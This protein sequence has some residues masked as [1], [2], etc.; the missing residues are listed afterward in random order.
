M[1]KIQYIDNLSVRLKEEIDLNFLHQ[2]GEVFWVLDSQ[3]SGNLCFGV[4][5]GENKYFIKFAGAKTI[6]NHDLPPEDAID[7]L[8]A[9]SKKYKDLAHPALIKLRDSMEIGNGYILIFDWETGNSIGDQNLLSRERFYSLSIDIR[10]N[11][12]SKILQFHKFVISSG[13]IA[14]DFNDNSTLYDFDNGKVTICDIDFYS[15]NPYMNGRGSIFG[16]KELMSPEE[17]RIAGLLDEVTNVYTMGATA[18]LLLSK[19]SRLQNEWPLSI[20]SYNV[21]KKATNETRKYRQQSID[22]L[23]KEWEKSIE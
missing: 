20:E 19:G 14:L 8:R 17:H 21:V 10:I 7:R 3:S 18:F 9:A 2:F 5:N 13:Y 1:E 11:V 16:I 22:E 15:K 4:K 23:I 6:N 12:F